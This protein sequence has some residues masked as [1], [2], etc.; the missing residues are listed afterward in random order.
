[1]KVLMDM[2]GL[3]TTLVVKKMERLLIYVMIGVG[4]FTLG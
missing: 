1:M 2:M 4:G 3:V